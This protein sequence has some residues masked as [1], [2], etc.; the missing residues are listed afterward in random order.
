MPICSTYK[1]YI[2]TSANFHDMLLTTTPHRMRRENLAMSD[3]S[4]NFSG[5]GDFG[6]GND[7]V[8]ETTTTGWLQRILGSLVGALI[9]I[10]LVIGSL[11]LRWGNEGRAVEAIR[12]L[13]QGAHHLVEVNSAAVDG[14]ADGKLVHLSGIVQTSKS[15]RDGSFGIR[16]DNLLLLHRPG[17]IVQTTEHTSTQ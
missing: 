7:S 5:S 2:Q 4:S 12:A 14:A 8:T 1:C 13:D 6:G 3:D 11:C 9:G 17:R 16:G 10:L 15:P